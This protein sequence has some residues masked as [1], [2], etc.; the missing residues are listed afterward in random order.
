MLRSV[1]LPRVAAAAARKVPVSMRSGGTRWLAPVSAG[2]PSTRTTLDP[3]PSMRAPMA[4]SSRARSPISGSMA[5]F[6]STVSPSAR[7][8]AIIRFSV[9]VT[10]GT[11]KA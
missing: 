9:P 8:A 10:D 7:A 1:T 4:V 11:S 5:A 6:S 2:L 3:A